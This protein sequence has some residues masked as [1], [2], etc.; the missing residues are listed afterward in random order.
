MVTMIAAIL[1]AIALLSPA[2]ASDGYTPPDNDHPDTERGTGT[3]FTDCT[4]RGSD[5]KEGCS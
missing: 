5:R 2:N 4:Y 3:R 1:S